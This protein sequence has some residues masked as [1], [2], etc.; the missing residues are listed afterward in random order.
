MLDNLQQELS[1]I[2]D[3]IEGFGH[4]FKHKVADVASHVVDGMK[5]GECIRSALCVPCP[6]SD[7][8]V[9]GVDI[10]SNRDRRRS[11]TGG[12]EQDAE[13]GPPFSTVRGQA[14]LPQEDTQANQTSPVLPRESKR[15]RA[16]QVKEEG[17]SYD[18]ND[19]SQNPLYDFL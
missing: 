13:G 4:D 11:T 19:G 8:T 3:D 12:G 1:H 5:S 16:R 9:A 18:E 7:L 2:K 10:I 15:G 14:P 17:A 6:G